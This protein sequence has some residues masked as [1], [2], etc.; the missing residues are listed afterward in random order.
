MKYKN[1]FVNNA[2][3]TICNSDCLVNGMNLDQAEKVA[4]A[5]KSMLIISPWCGDINITIEDQNAP[6]EEFLESIE[7][8]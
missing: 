7:S 6:C 2:F 1:V 4:E 3:V 8:E 5:V